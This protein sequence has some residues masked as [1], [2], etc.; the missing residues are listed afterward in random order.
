MKGKEVASLVM[1]SIDSKEGGRGCV[2]MKGILGNLVLHT[3]VFQP[4][5][6]QTTV[7]P[8]SVLISV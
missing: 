4:G 1:L 5:I 7:F 6:W 3:T 8:S 2:A